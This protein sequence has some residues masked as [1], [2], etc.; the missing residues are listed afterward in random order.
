MSHEEGTGA[1]TWNQ[2]LDEVIRQMTAAQKQQIYETVQV[3]RTSFQRWRSGDNLP[4]A[5]RIQPL[6]AALPAEARER[7][8]AL[9]VKDARL[10]AILPNELVNPRIPSLADGIASSFY[11][12]ILRIQR[13][14]ADPFWQVSNAVVQHA[15]TELAPGPQRVGLNIVVAR[16]M[17]AHADGK[18]RSLRTLLVMGTP[19]WRIDL[20]REDG[21]FGAESLPGRAIYE[22]RSVMVP[23]LTD[24]LS[25]A[26]PQAHERSAAAVPIMRQGTIAGAL[27]VVSQQSDFFTPERLTRVEQYAD[28]VR[29]AFREGDFVPSSHI[30]LAIMPS[31]KAQ[32][33]LLA[34]VR[35][36][37][38][39]AYQQT[40][41]QGGAWQD[42]NEVEQRAW[43]EIELEL[44][45]LAI[46]EAAGSMNGT[47]RATNLGHD[48]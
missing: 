32:Q 22:R 34:T 39:S 20:H 5:T 13:E 18:V 6:L 2:Y 9:M 26:P 28:L 27:L 12:D 41:A 36:R 19:P 25:P 10:R 14:A 42:L 40:L 29:L 3:S 48:G 16:C 8:V 7:L 1:Q 21:F 11:A 33:P 24:P 35:E 44:M 4:D 23:D 47:D 17:P 46:R 45:Y 43:K 37:T 31:W 15:I 38:T 30:M